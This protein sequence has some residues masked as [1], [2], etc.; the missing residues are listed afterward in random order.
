MLQTNPPF[1]HLPCRSALKSSERIDR[2]P[3]QGETLRTLVNSSTE[4]AA[5]TEPKGSMIWSWEGVRTLGGWW[6]EVE[7]AGMA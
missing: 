7:R 2:K 6:E 3:V 1:P 4:V 5:R